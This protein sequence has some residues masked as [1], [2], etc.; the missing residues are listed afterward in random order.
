MS[1]TRKKELIYSILAPGE[2]G[3]RTGDEQLIDMY[4]RGCDIIE[5][6]KETHRDPACIAG[7][8]M[9]LGETDR[10]KSIM[11]GQ[12]AKTPVGKGPLD[13]VEGAKALGVA[14]LLEGQ[15]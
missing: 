11:Y 5:M 10:I 7:R 3:R 9:Y 4:K 6:S 12:K 14:G 1:Y 15:K 2:C 8:I 13:V